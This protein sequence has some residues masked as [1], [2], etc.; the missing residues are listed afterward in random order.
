M[1]TTYN[2]RIACRGWHVYGKDV[3]QHPRKDEILYGQKEE[4]QVA[5][6]ID[7][8]AIA[9]MKRSRDR[10]MPYIVGHIPLEISRYVRFFLDRGGKVEAK[11][12]DPRY[13]PS[14]IP[15]GGLEIILQ[16]TFSI[17]DE[18][19]VYIQRLQELIV[20]N[21]DIPQERVT[22]VENEE[23]TCSNDQ[24]NDV[25]S[26]DDEFIIFIDDEEEEGG[27]EEGEAAAAEEE[28]IIVD[29]D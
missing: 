16:A 28:P 22:V 8:H 10:L 2:V 15:K 12:H 29:L 20:G 3:W 1:E 5:L 17:S 6:I 21:Y 18:K 26:H 7:P 25:L 24:E 4:N 23:A 9:W 11:V 27:E 19:R 14:P 13:R